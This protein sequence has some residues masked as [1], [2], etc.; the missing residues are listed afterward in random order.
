MGC[1]YVDANVFI[2]AFE[3]EQ[4][5]AAPARSPL[6]AGQDKPFSLVTSELT[7]AE[8]LAPSSAPDALPWPRKL[9]VYRTLFIWTGFLQVVPVTRSI[10]LDTAPLRAAHRQ[11][12][13][14]AIHA[15]TA[16]HTGCRYFCS[17][18]RDARRLPSGLTH[19]LP[20]EAWIAQA[21]NAI[22][23]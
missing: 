6:R 8:V 15:V 2:A 4:V 18:D 17:A 20:N 1:V 7:I 16:F 23:A 9:E 12:L 11:K 3:A 22:S 13:P 5:V 10:L 14:D 21:L 19:L